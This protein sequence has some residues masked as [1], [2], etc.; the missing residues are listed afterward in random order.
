MAAD[1]H[2]WHK[3]GGFVLEDNNNKK[4]K[5]SCVKKV[6]KYTH[7]IPDKMF[8]PRTRSYK[9][10]G[11]P[12]FHLKTGIGRVSYCIYLELRCGVALFIMIYSLWSF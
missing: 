10:H 4:K 5:N 12:D 6:E 7:S 1:L 8:S 9:H 2:N 3:V 11:S